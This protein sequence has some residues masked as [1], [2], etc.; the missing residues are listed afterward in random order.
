[1]GK[2]FRDALAALSVPAQQLKAINAVSADLNKFWR[3]HREFLGR[4]RNVLAAHREQDALAYAQALDSIKPLEVMHRAAEL[5]QLL[6]VLV[7]QLIA[8]G[9]L[10]S[11][12]AGILADIVRSNGASEKVKG[13]AA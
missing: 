4:I 6:E 9:Q 1:L 3:T 12:P 11:G 2:R 10:T 8:M 13:T 7:Q 5:S